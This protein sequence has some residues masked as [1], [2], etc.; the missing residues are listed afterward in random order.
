[1]PE[2]KIL[3]HVINFMESKGLTHKTIWV[4]ID[5]DLVAKVNTINKTSYKL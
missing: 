1:M 5:E 2:F 4:S 3:N